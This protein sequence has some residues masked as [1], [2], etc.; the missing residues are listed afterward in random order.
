MHRLE[1]EAEAREFGAVQVAQHITAETER[2]KRLIEI[3]SI[4][5]E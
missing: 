5:S 4:K 1:T 3:T 2:W